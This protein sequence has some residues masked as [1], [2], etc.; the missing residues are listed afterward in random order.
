MAVSLL[1]EES[2]ENNLSQF[3]DRLDHISLYNYLCKQEPFLNHLVVTSFK[4]HHFEDCL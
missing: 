4:W 2:V 3:T 1:L